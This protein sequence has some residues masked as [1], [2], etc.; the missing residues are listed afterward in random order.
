MSK[1]KILNS[2][3]AKQLN[4]DEKQIA[5]FLYNNMTAAYANL[6]QLGIKPGKDIKNLIN[7]V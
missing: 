1:E 7:G 6:K 3:L 5:L 2:F 4:M